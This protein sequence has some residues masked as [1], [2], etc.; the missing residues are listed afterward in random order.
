MIHHRILSA[1]HKG[2][3]NAIS[4]L[5]FYAGSMN[6]RDP[7]QLYMLKMTGRDFGLIYNDMITY[8]TEYI[9]KPLVARSSMA[10]EHA[11]IRSEEHTSELQS[12]HDLVCRLL[13]EK[14]KTH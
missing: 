11:E 14:N 10:A 6:Y 12:H 5:T 8:E 4:R 9:M 1:K 13:L 3:R 7:D 2:L